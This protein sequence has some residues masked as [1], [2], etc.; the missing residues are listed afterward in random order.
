MASL[1]RLLTA[2]AALALASCTGGG[3]REPNT[4]G[5]EPATCPGGLRV[6]ARRPARALAAPGPVDETVAPAG[7][8]L[9]V[10]ALLPHTGDLGFLGA[11]TSAAVELAVE[12]I[13]AAAGVLGRPVRLSHVDSAE[14]TAGA[15]E[16]A[17]AEHLA[18]GADAVIGPLSSSVAAAVLPSV[19]ASGAV[20]VT[21][22]ATASALDTIDGAGR[23]FRTV[24]A[25]AVQ[26]RALAEL[27]LDDGAR[28]A[29]IVVR[30][31]DHGRAVADAFTDTF[32]AGGGR[33]AHRVERDP[34]AESVDL[35]PLAA[36]DVDATVLI[37]LADTAPAVDALAAA[38]RGPR[39]RLTYGTDGSLGD[40]LGDLVADRRSLACMRGLL[41]A[42]PVPQN[43]ARRL[44]ERLGERA[45][46]ADLSYA[47]EA[48]DAV[49]A[50]AVAA[51][52]AR[53]VEAEAVAAALPAV[54]DAGRPCEGPAACL[55]L[56]RS[57]TDVAVVGAS[58]ALRMDEAGNRTAVTLT[59]AAFGPSGRLVRLGARPS[60]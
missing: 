60:G 17:L 40:R 7:D 29:G 20:L 44:E 55:R 27:V 13:D 19:A 42:A 12:D 43:L 31:D 54:T 28:H 37:G 4:S 58:G 46:G 33:I 24:A 50:V 3:D 57:G 53:S 22:G 18:A 38:G 34:S 6:P 9:D 41:A 8:G 48:Y 15:A 23:L 39:Q 2:I 11:A 36:S 5:P 21:P 56:V 52:T 26:G 35:G 45:S 30:A 16:A 25:E 1:P 32:V 51:E 59:L 14:G 10:V 47:A 49:V